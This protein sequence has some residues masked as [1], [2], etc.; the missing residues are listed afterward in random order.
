MT[1]ALYNQI[2]LICL[3]RQKRDIKFDK[4]ILLV[5]IYMNAIQ[6]LLANYDEISYTD[7]KRLND[8]YQYLYNIIQ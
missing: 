4:R 2:K 6:N 8:I 1:V 3:Q 7:I 5:L